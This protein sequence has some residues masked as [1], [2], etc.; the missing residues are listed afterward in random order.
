MSNTEKT[1]K[2][3]YCPQ[4]I[5]DLLGVKVLTIYRW[6][7]SGKLH[8]VKIGQWRISESDLQELLK[9]DQNNNARPTS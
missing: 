3:Y 4:E 7:K 6:I 1:E 5:A 9:G 8:A 2:G